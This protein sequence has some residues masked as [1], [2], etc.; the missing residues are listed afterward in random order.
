VKRR[1]HMYEEKSITSSKEVRRGFC[2]IM[3]I[4]TLGAIDL[5]LCQC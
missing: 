5:N 1:L 3:L 2:D 4:I